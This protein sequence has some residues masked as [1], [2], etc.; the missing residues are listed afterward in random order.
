MKIQLI[1]LTIITVASCVRD[2]RLITRFLQPSYGVQPVIVNGDPATVGQIPYFV[3]IKEVLRWYKKN[4]ALWKSFCGGTIIAINKV[5][6]AAHCFE[7]NDYKY[8]QRPHLLRV[9]AGSIRNYMIHSGEE[10]TE[11][12]NQ[13]R[14]IQKIV[15]HASFNFPANDIALVFVN[16]FTYTSFVTYAIPAKADMDYA[17]RCMAAGFGK[18]GQDMS[19]QAS[20]VLLVAKIE[21]LSKYLCSNRWLSDMD[22]F[23]CSD[24]ESADVARGDSGGPLVCKGTLDPAER[25]GRDLLVGIVSG[26]DVDRTTI[27]TRVSAYKDWIERGKISKS[28]QESSSAHYSS[29]RRGSELTPS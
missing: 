12:S 2:K 11:N 6:T 24:A 20:H 13:W 23:I 22:K 19:N 5:L 8:Y 10:V 29:P 9:V 15:I 27:Y 18:T 7:V 16:N 21:L 3:S 14:K 28:Y 1:L 26:K 4:S 17:R 25:S